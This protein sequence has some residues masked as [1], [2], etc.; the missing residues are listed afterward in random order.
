MATALCH[1]DLLFSGEQL[2]CQKKLTFSRGQYGSLQL[3]LWKGTK[4]EPEESVA[5]KRIKSNECLENWKDI[6]GDHVNGI[7]S[8]TNIIRVVGF[9]DGIDDWRLVIKF[10][11]I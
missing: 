7:L 5:V 4:S 1:E 10:V 6:I 3:G 8:H 9:E 11:V 2:K